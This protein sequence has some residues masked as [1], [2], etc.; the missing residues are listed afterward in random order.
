MA[1]VDE[2]VTDGDSSMALDPEQDVV[3]RLPPGEGLDSEGQP[4]AGREQLRR[5][6][7]ACAAVVGGRREH[8]RAEAL[9]EAAGVTLVPWIRQKDDGLEVGREIEDSG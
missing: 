1:A 2:R 4:V 8:G 7:H 3:R 9:R 5:H 6:P